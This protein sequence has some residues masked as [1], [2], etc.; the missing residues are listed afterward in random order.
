MNNIIGMLFLHKQREKKT[1]IQSLFNVGRLLCN[2][3]R[4]F[5][6]SVKM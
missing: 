2:D 5:V 3:L 1:T 4:G 6:T